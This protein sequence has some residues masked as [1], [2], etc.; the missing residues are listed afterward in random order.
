MPTHSLLN[1]A[2]WRIVSPESA[3]LGIE[4]CDGIIAQ[5]W[6][7]TA[8]TPNV[9]QGVRKERTFEMAFCE[10]ASAAALARHTD[11]R[12]WLLSDITNGLMAIPNLIGLLLLSGVI[13]SETRGYFE[14]QA[15]RGES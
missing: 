5:V 15:A 1:Y 3:L 12:V 4:D 8:R 6:T 11:L 10:Y 14:R 9:Y 2:H 7:G 13:V